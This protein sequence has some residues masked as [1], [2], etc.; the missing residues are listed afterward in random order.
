VLTHY[1]YAVTRKETAS[2]RRWHWA[3]Y[4]KIDRS[5]LGHR[6]SA[7]TLKKNC[8]TSKIEYSNDAYEHGYMA[9]QDKVTEA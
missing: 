2:T 8:V 5:F 7:H 4:N 6:Y 3:I 1:M 9:C